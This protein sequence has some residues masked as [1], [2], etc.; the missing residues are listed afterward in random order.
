MNK[1]KNLKIGKQT[2]DDLIKQMK[3]TAFNARSLGEAV[4][5]I[6]KMITDKNCVKFLG[7]S[8]ALV[9][10]GMR[11][12]IVEMIKRN[13]IDIIVSTGANITHDIA[14]CFGETYD[15]IDPEY[16]DDLELRK[17][18]FDRIYDLVSPVETME[19]M[20]NN[21]LEIL[22]KI[23]EKEYSTF[24]L[25]NEIGKHLNDNQSIV[26]NAHLNKVK[27]IVPAFIDSVLGLQVW[28]NSQTRN[29]KVNEFKD[30]GYVVNLNFDLKKKGKNT[31]CLILGGGVPKNFILQSVLMADKPHKYVVQITTDTP[32]YGGLSGATLKEAL[33]WGKVDEKSLFTT[34]YCDTTIALPLIVNSLI[35][36]L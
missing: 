17:K 21:I 12:C 18:G 28:V 15:Q 36:R 23:D 35:E 34:V 22:N 27:L 8:G 19:T 7:L 31:G 11:L 26:R 16:V 33:S 2:I 25:L 20:E 6:E 10:S 13:W 29:L 5:I 14:Q 24:E 4:D 9:P 1:W 32:H 3:Y 30:L